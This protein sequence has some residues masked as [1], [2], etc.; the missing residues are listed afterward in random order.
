MRR[1]GALALLFVASLTRADPVA[2]QILDDTLAE[3][4]LAQDT[5]DYTARFLEA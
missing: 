2:A 3:D 5:V 4:S 1:V